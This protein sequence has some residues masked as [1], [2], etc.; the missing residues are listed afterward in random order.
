MM[1]DRANN[2]SGGWPLVDRLSKYQC[3]ALS[4]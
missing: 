4:G 3:E 1:A 2:T